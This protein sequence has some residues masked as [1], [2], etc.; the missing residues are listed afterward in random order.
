MTILDGC[1][2]VDFSRI[3]AG[4]FLTQILAD[5]G[6]DVVKI[7][8]SGLGDEA[9]QYGITDP[10][11]P[12]PSFTSL[13]RNKR[14]IT[15]DMNTPAGREAARR[16]V[17]GADVVIEN[18]R[19][20]VMAAWDL[21][22]EAVAAAN[23]GVVYCSISGFGSRGPRREKAANDLIIQAMSGLL[24]ITGEPGGRPVRAGTSVADFS[25][26]LYGVIGVLGA[27]I[28]KQNTGQ[29]QRVE[30][31]LIDS[32]LSLMS[33]HLTDFW[34]TGRVARPLGT[35]NELGLPNQAFPTIDGWIVLAA[36]SDRM[37]AKCCNALAMGHLATDPRFAK[38]RDRY[39]HRD[40]LISEIARAT[41]VLSTGD[42]I[43]RL[44]AAG[45]SCGP[46]MDIAEVADD[47]HVRDEVSISVQTTN[48]SLTRTIGSPLRFG[49][50]PVRL[51]RGVPA[52]GEHT[53]EILD[54]LGLGA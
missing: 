40:Y 35:A 29:G 3:F 2:V 4:P 18:F 47:R 50:T 27:I 51:D 12:S 8:R 13:N 44:E 43:T 10:N 33:Y 30:V 9:R 23:P 17:L 31:S 1:R 14:S 38:L 26:G 39:T 6:A 21:D 49:R 5:L 34:L 54:E 7:E 46:V 52:L 36:T 48:G 22:Y 11:S 45:V 53:E 15:L 16:L 20:G 24:S 19:S 32:Q 28:H 25:A 41:S 37:W 42:C